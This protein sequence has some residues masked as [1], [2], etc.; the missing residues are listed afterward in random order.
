[1]KLPEYLISLLYLNIFVINGINLIIE[2]IKM[3]KYSMFEKILKLNLIVKNKTN[4]SNNDMISSMKSLGRIAIN[5]I[6]NSEY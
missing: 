4:A 1:M 5:L 6:F 2:A 3:P